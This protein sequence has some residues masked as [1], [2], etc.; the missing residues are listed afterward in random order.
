M[1][2]CV[3]STVFNRPKRCTM[4]RLPNRVVPAYSRAVSKAAELPNYCQ[5]N[6]L[7]IPTKTFQPEDE[8]VR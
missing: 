8:V 6:I 7:G 2:E 1:K 4:P 3:T 5:V